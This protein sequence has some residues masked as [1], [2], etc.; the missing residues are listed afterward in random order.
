[1]K[2]IIFVFVI[3]S[4]FFVGCSPNIEIVSHK[5]VNNII[6][7]NTTN[8]TATIEVMSRVIETTQYGIDEGSHKYYNVSEKTFD[9]YNVGDIF[10]E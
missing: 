6:H 9:S 3:I 7:L 8:M 1:M 2:N 4:S 5:E 10:I